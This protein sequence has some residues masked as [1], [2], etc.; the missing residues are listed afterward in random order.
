MTFTPTRRCF[1][2][3]SSALGAGLAAGGLGLT[4]AAA[5]PLAFRY[6]YSAISWGT[7]IEEAIK[8]G[9]RLKMP[10]IEP[11]RDNVLN[12]LNKPLALKKLMDDA[13]VQMVTCSNGGGPDFSGNFFDPAKTPKTIADHIK[14]AR[15]F[16]RPF[17]YC[18]HFKMNNGPRP[19]GYDV[20]DDQIKV[21]AD[22]LNAIGMETIKFGIKLAPHPHVGSLIQTEHET[23]KLMELTDPRYVWLTTDTSHLTLGGM[24]PLQ[25]MKDYWPR[26]AEVHYKDAPRHLRGN[27]TLAVPKT[28]PE[29]GGHG[30]FRNLGGDV[31]HPD[32]GGVDFPA[33]QAFLI[34]KNFKGWVTLDLDASMI[35]KGSNMEE[36]IKGNLKYLVDVLHVDPATV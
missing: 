3:T 12:Y 24:D 26:V 36:T 27:K 28:G 21:C 11:F 8:V 30:W 7:N 33:I 14:L 15:D 34:E 6:G 35:P 18:D 31:D 17:G 10:G 4:P 13:G 2:Q 29:A 1:L 32:S 9:Q 23:R 5:K 25:I 20:S 16:I 22:A 19:P